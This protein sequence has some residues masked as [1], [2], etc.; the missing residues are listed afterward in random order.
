M[1]L[2]TTNKCKNQLHIHRKQLKGMHKM[3]TVVIPGKWVFL[4]F[5]DILQHTGNNSVISGGCKVKRNAGGG[6]NFQ[7]HQIQAMVPVHYRSVCHRP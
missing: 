2:K 6:P 1:E 3:L 7:Q 4:Y 5:P